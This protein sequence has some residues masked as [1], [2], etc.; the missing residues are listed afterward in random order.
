MSPA[1]PDVS[2]SERSAPC[3]AYLI[4]TH[5]DPEQV[6][7]LAARILALSPH[8]QVVVHHDLASD[9][10]PW[11]GR[12]PDRVHFVERERIL[13]GGWSIVEATLRMVT[14]ALQELRAD[15]FVVLSGEHW[16]VEDLRAWELATIA[17]GIDAFVTAEPLPHRL[18]FGRGDD[19]TNGANMFLSR[20][21]HRWVTVKQPRAAVAHRAVGGFWKLSRYVMPIVTVEYSHRRETWFFGRPRARGRMRDW[22]FY[23]GSQWIAFNRRSAETILDADPAVTE[24]FR[25]GHIP[26]ETYFHTVLRHDKDLVVTKDVV[27]YVPIGPKTPT[28]RWMVLKIEELPDVWR[29]G[30]AFARKVD[31]ADRP[32]VIRALNA[33]VDRRLAGGPRLDRSRAHQT[34]LDSHPPSSEHGSPRSPPACVAVVGM[35]RSGT[36]ATAG[37]LVGM[38]LAGPK[39]DDL[40]PAEESNERGHWESETVIMHSVKVLGTLGAHSYAPPPPTS[41]WELD[42]KFDSLRAEAAQWLADVRRQDGRL[43]RSTALHDPPTLEDGCF[44]PHPSSLRAPRPPGGGS[45]AAG[46]RRSSDG[47]RPVALGSLRALRRPEPRGFA[48]PR[49]RL[50]RD[51]GRSGQVERRDL[52]ISRGVGR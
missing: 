26:D 24:W 2:V 22:E 18:R 44:R 6:E 46:P 15:W 33:E 49:R 28:L 51:V 9:D 7:A 32:E 31:L 50:H 42:R 21:L 20:C 36:S 34:T 45:F 37:L 4:L 16:P 35:H 17:S 48:D 10:L 13:W 52:W 5:K 47:P 14:F 25:R 39:V 41:G 19:E 30:A 8:G 29:S 43:E 27:T 12:P 38:G 11:R 3:F 23:K 40:V 1:R